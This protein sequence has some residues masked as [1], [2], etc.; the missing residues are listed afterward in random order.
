MNTCMLDA[1]KEGIFNVHMRVE[2]I[3]SASELTYSIAVYARREYK[4]VHGEKCAPSIM[5]VQ[6]KETTLA[7]CTYNAV[8]QPDGSAQLTLAVLAEPPYNKDTTVFFYPRVSLLQDMVDTVL[9]QWLN[10]NV[11]TKLENAATFC[12]RYT[13][14]YEPLFEIPVKDLD[15]MIKQDLVLTADGK[16]NNG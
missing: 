1:D 12:K 10:T 9:K 11:V 16:E 3:K 4:Y 15:Y 6:P 5:I 2:R 14:M 7:L 8:P 13:T